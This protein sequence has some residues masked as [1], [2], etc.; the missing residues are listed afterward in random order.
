MNRFKRQILLLVCSPS[1]YHSFRSPFHRSSAEQRTLIDM[2]DRGHPFGDFQPSRI[3][4]LGPRSLGGRDAGI[5][6]GNQQES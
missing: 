2:D 1:A 3:G 6:D 5:P 4:E